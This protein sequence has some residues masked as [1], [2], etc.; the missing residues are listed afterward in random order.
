M[1]F[2][3]HS[4]AVDGLLFASALLV[5]GAGFTALLWSFDT[6][7]PPAEWIDSSVDGTAPSSHTQSMPGTVPALSSGVLTGNIFDGVS[8]RSGG[9]IAPMSWLS[10][11]AS[12]SVG[13]APRATGFSLRHRAPSTTFSAP[14]S[15]SNRASGPSGS[16]YGSTLRRGEASADP[17]GWVGALASSSGELQSLERQVGAI[18]RHLSA[19]SRKGASRQMMQGDERLAD[20][21]GTAL[22]GPRAHSGDAPLPDDPL[23]PSP[24][25]P[26][27]PVPVDGGLALLLAAGGLYGVRRLQKSG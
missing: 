1:S 21:F 24:P 4:S 5:V 14:H 7:P 19:R 18:E 9:S 17:A 3:S 13:Q 23:S 12:A 15:V 20:G 8:G 25:L 10:P 2:T 11:A 27:D 16:G 22:L 26:A 6:A